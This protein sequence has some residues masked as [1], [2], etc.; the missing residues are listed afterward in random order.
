MIKPIQ[1]RNDFHSCDRCGTDINT[2]DDYC[3]SCYYL[4]V[5][6]KLPESSYLEA[7]VVQTGDPS[8]RVRRF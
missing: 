1:N 4:E 7:L 8:P 6:G 2:K 3:N 5:A